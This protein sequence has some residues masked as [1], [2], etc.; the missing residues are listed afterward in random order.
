MTPLAAAARDRAPWYRAAGREKEILRAAAGAGL[1]VLLKGPTGCGKSRFVEAMAHELGRP[2]I[3]VACNEETSAV[4]L[5]GR[6]LVVGGD[7]VWQDGPAVRAAR[8]GAL[9]YLDEVA[10]A[11]ADVLVVIHPLADHRRQ[12][13]IDRR[14]EVVTAAPGFLLVA[15]FNPGYQGALKELKPSTRQRFVTLAFDW[16]DAAA[17]VEIVAVESGA[18][19]AVCKRLVAFARKVRSQPELGLAETVSTR[20]L[21]AAGRLIVAG[22]PPRA[23]CEAAIVQPLTDDRDITAALTNAV[24]LAF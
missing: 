18:D 6:H 15:S 12:L 4:D 11:R 9:L 2:L 21:V 13:W 3:T 19:A 24:H 20:L 23:A 22:V 8:E 10:E 1:P 14:N 17:E 16:P 7:T 5:C